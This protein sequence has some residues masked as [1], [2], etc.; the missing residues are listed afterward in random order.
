ME[1]ALVCITTRRITSPPRGKFCGMANGGKNSGSKWREEH[2]AHAASFF[3]ATSC[4]LCHAHA[5]C[6]ITSTMTM[7][8]PYW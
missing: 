8:M 7:T 6:N 1:L 4:M 5:S 2:A 3:H